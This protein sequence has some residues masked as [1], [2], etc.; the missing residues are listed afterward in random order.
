MK[1]TK[2][3]KVRLPILLVSGSILVG[4][5]WRIGTRCG[6]ILAD[7]YVAWCEDYTAKQLKKKTKL[8]SVQ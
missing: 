3:D 2:G 4:T 8:E 1:P 7:A 5:G 6:D